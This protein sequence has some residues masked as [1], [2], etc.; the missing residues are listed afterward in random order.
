MAP[1][2]YGGFT[3]AR[4]EGGTFRD[5]GVGGPQVQ[6]VVFVPPDPVETKVARGLLPDS[7]PRTRTPRRTRDVPRCSW[8]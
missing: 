8:R 7:V 6:V 5:V 3:I 4:A 1:A 2:F